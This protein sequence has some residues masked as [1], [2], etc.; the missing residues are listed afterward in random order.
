[1]CRRV[2]KILAEAN[3]RETAEFEALKSQIPED[4]PPTHTDLLDDDESPGEYWQHTYLMNPV[5][6]DGIITAWQCD[7]CGYEQAP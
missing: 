7:G 3:V 6:I 2:A 1:V 5:V 4:G